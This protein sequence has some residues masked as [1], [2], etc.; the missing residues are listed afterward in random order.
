M[1][2]V[3][4]TNFDRE[5]IR[6]RA[7]KAAFET[8][9][10]DLAHREHAL[11]KEAYEAV[12]PADERAKAAKLPENW[13]RRD[14]CLGFNVAGATVRLETGGEGFPVPFAPKGTQKGSY[15]CHNRLGV[16]PAGDLADRIMSLMADKEMLKEER[17]KARSAL[18]AMLASINTTSKLGETWPEGR[19]F[20]GHLEAARDKAAVPS[21]RVAEVNNLLG[22]PEAV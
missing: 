3:R 9:N 8:R 7:L 20:F 11:A 4:L 19:P 15:D 17:R 6:D 5:D 10:V 21:V 16:I 22:I 2:S 18:Q 1:P 14:P 13:L 12:I